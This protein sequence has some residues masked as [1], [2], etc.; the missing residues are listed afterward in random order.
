MISWRDLYISNPRQ[1]PSLLISE[2]FT[3]PLFPVT[4]LLLNVL[5]SHR[6]TSLQSKI[7]RL[8]EENKTLR[9]IPKGEVWYY[10]DDGQ[11]YP[12]SLACPVIMEPNVLRRLLDN[13]RRKD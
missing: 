9:R 3:A 1:F 2:H 10:G 11:D 12:D 13:A 7:N 4:K 5:W 8:G 6:I